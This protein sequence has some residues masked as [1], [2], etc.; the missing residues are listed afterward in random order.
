MSRI[1]KKLIVILGPTAS[2]K[3]ALSIKLAKNFNGEI[4][5]ADSRQVYKGMNIGTGKVTKKEMQ[6]IKHYLL[7]VASPKRRF[8][9]AQY[10]RLALEAINK[11][12]KKNKVPF[13]VG[14][15]PFY[16]YSVVEKWIFP[17]LKPDQKLRKE[18]EKKSAKELFQILKKLDSKR[19]KTIEK[20]N[21]RRLI[22]AIEIAKKLG[23]VPL[24]K[25]TPQFNC[26]LIGI[27]KSKEELKKLIE[28]RLLKRLKKGM[29]EEVRK[30][31]REG[32][33]WQR[34]EEFGLEYRWIA[35]YLQGKIDYEE[36][37][38]NLQKD[39]EHFAK[40]QMTWF[41]K[42]KR[43][44]WTPSTHHPYRWAKKLIKEFLKK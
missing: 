22:R 19:A 14:G 40:H 21:K 43:I 13:L 38:K 17:K 23:R 44:K 35:K 39:I 18:L 9:V 30:L 5:S 28:K 29:I 10:Q 15:S 26:L 12:L 4:V 25:K 8:S 24:L 34:L 33:S 7:D 36:M 6:G 2:G 42:D 3:T 41:K 31:R 11:I 27:K 32:L 16:I 37:I 20:E 1:T